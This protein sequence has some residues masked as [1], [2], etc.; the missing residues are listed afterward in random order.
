[1][2]SKD[3]KTYNRYR[4]ILDIFQRHRGGKS[5]IKLTDLASRVGVSVRQLG[6]DLKYMKAQGAPLEYNAS[7]RGWYYGEGGDIAFV[8]GKLLTTDDVLNLRIA[9]ETFNKINPQQQS[10][11]DLSQVFQKIYTAARRWVKPGTV[12]KV[13]YFD[14]LPR[15][16]GGKHLKFFLNAIEAFRRVSFEYLAYHASSPKTVEFDPWFLRHYD[17][18][19]YVGGFSHDPEEGFVRT[20]PL[21]RITGTPVTIG[22]F[23]DK[24]P[25][26]DAATYWKHIYGIT[27][28]PDRGVENVILEFTP[29]QG[30]YFLDTPFYEPFEVLERD[31]VKLVVRFQ[32]IPNMD[33]QRKLASFGAEVRVLAP[34]SL[35]ETMLRFH[36]KA[37]AAYKA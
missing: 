26:F 24:P 7:E 29:L 36:E 34:Q 19:W 28:P 2:M 25:D 27:I 6:D 10:S 21:E 31:T 22:F 20:F 9:M 12:T 14:P 17:R 1:M 4:D 5:V 33:L 23:H 16:E 8:E 32:L 11:E 18:R 35:A 15:Y 3:N 13:I 30:R 37:V